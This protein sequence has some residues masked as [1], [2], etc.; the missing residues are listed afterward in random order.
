MLSSQVAP[1]TSC[2]QTTRICCGGYG[3]RATKHCRAC[4]LTHKGTPFDGD[5][6]D[7]YRRGGM[8]AKDIVIAWDLTWATGSAVTYLL[9]AGKKTADP[10]GDLLKAR[11]MIDIE[12]QRLK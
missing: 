9:R 2:G 10:R 1:C 7:Y 3:D 4:C 8:E 5:C 6:P 12:L 11:D